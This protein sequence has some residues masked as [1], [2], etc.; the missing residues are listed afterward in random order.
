[1]PQALADIVSSLNDVYAPQKDVVNQQ[2]A[3]IPADQA[4][5]Q[6]GLDQTKTN[7]FGSIVSGA[8]ARGMLYSGVPIDEQAKYLGGTY[9]P[10]VAKLQE[11]VQAHKFALQDALAKITGAQTA[12]AYGIQGAQAKEE[13][14]QANADRTYQL[15]QLKAQ[16]SIAA[17]NRVG[18]G[19][20]AA[21]KDYNYYSDPSGGF[22]FKDPQG[23]AVT[24][25]QY[26]SAKGT[27]VAN[28][29][30]NSRNPADAQ[31]LSEMQSGK[32]T[33]SDLQKKYPWIFGGV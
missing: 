19:G 22:Q 24:A 15:E 28:L 17:S 10:A 20:G 8:N 4:A 7:A 23:H 6:A 16:A 14:A 13:N 2:M 27:S 1:M 3:A 12:Q 31:V 26:A 5:Q 33:A 29:L 30:V 25:A 18:S 32:V 9:L 11:A 21:A